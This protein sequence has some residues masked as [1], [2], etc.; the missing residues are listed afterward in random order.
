[1]VS[2]VSRNRD[3]LGLQR[4]TRRAAGGT[5]HSMPAEERSAVVGE[6]K[7][8]YTVVHVSRNGAPAPDYK[9]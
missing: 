2:G 9:G 7:K 4:V 5:L 6:R 8:Q 3:F 1:M